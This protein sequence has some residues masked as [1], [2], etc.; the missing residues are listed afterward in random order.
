MSL[1][2]ERRARGV[3]A[4]CA[5]CVRGVCAVCAVGAGARSGFARLV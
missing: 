2:E 5:R 3:C 4:V 1:Q